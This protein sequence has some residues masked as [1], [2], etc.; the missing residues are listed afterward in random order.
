MRSSKC[1]GKDECCHKYLKAVLHWHLL[2]RPPKTI[3]FHVPAIWQAGEHP[4]HN[5]ILWSKYRKRCP[6]KNSLGNGSVSR[7][8]KACG[9]TA[10]EFQESDGE[11]SSNFSPTLAISMKMVLPESNSHCGIVY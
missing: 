5:Y 2:W 7:R 9:E 3:E 8:A 11:W 4:F 6:T 10:F 1:R